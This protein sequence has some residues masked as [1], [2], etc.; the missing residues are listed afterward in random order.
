M[1]FCLYLMALDLR[2]ACIPRLRHYHTVHFD[3]PVWGLSIQ[4]L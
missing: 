2:T 1:P 4:I 3:L